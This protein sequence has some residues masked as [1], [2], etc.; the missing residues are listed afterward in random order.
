[1]T[2]EEIYANIRSLI[3]IPK[4]LTKAVF[5]SI[6]GRADIAHHRLM[7]QS[8]LVAVRKDEY[9]RDGLPKYTGIGVI[10][11]DELWGHLFI[12]TRLPYGL[13]RW[14]V[15]EPATV[16]THNLIYSTYKMSM[17]TKKYPNPSTKDII[18]FLQSNVNIIAKNV[19]DQKYPPMRVRLR[20]NNRARVPP[21]YTELNVDFSARE[22]GNAS[23]SCTRYYNYFNITEA[24]IEEVREVYQNE[25]LESAEEHLK[26]LVNDNIHGEDVTD[27]G[28]YDYSTEECED[29]DNYCDDTD[30]STLIQQ[31]IP[32][33]EE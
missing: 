26:Q 10:G 32:E 23:Y 31:I 19:N 22:W 29:V 8:P 21:A 20:A 28:D 18:E 7:P 9:V 17:D 4:Q 5:E 6:D 27:W 2:S 33:A 1:M 25:D 11:E 3:T 14:I 13:A 12:A 16:I 30:Y 15:M 24:Q